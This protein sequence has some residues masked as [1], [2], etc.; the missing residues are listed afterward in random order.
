MTAKRI[1]LVGCGPWGRHILRDLTALGCEV[2][3]VARSEA[4]RSR[5]RD[6]GA[7]AIVASASELPDVDGVVVAPATVSH[8]EAIEDVLE[9]DVP[10]FVEKPLTPDLGDA[11]RLAAAA[12]DR[13]FVM[14]KWRYHDGVLALAEI[15]RSGEFGAVRSLHTRRVG[16]GNP[17]RD[18]DGIWI[19]APHDLA[20]AL[21]VLGS[22]PTPVAAAAEVMD[23]L[24]VGMTAVLREESGVPFSFEVS[25]AAPVRIR[26]VRL[27]C[28]EGVATLDDGYADHVL[29][30]RGIGGETERRAISDE[31]PLLRELRA[32]V[33]HLGGGPPP[34][35]SAAEGAAMVRVLSELRSLAG[36]ESGVAA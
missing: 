20:I 29:V 22:L 24:P 4:S 9:R 12:P 7:A 21:E 6:G 26:S 28:D 30:A 11:E 25:A 27:I 10:V 36:I 2:S 8:A 1:G 34:K 17:H 15:A 3:V 16:W 23:G 14:D 35:S 19:L 13:L 31:M 33:E 5:A 18:V 32:F